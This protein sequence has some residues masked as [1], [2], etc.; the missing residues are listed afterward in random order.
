MLAPVLTD[1][2]PEKQDEILKRGFDYGQSRV[3]CRVH[4]LSD[5]TAGRLIASAT[6][7]RLQSDPTFRVQLKLM[8]YH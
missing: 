6:F 7:A 1:L 5:T 8:S 2:V 4:W 3:V